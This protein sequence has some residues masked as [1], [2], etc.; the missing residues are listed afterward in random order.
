MAYRVLE[1]GRWYWGECPAC[2]CRFICS[3]DEIREVFNY[4]TQET[5]L[6][7]DCPECMEE[8]EMKLED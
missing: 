6:Y 3:K 5:K 1:R 8:T 2:G 7:R 4:T